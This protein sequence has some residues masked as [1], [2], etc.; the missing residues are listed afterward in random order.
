M[1]SHKPVLLEQVLQVLK[2]EPEQNFVDATLGGGGYTKAILQALKSQGKV[3][4]LDLDLDAITNAQTQ[5][6]EFS[7]QLLVDHRNFRD[8]DKSIKKYDFQSIDGIVA[9]IGLSSYQLDNSGRGIS[10]ESHDRLDMRFDQ[11]SSQPD[12]SFL[13]NNWT[14][15]ELTQIFNKFGEE[16]FSRLIAKGILAF[17]SE[18]KLETADQL[19]QIIQQSLPKPVKHQWQS[20]ARRIFQALR[21]EVNHELENLEVFLPKALNLLKPGGILAVVT[22][23]SLEDRIVK[24]FFKANSL[25]CVCPPEFPICKCG[26]TPTVKILTTKPVVATEHELLENPRARSA[27]MR[28]IQKLK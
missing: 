13:L 22:F 21:I 25:S 17:R 6:A 8:L 26:Q 15:Q 20:S 1:Y 9:D 14:E 4:A 10:F 27:K 2:P 18:Q 28:A 3:L 16:K 7:S 12:A 24:H 5:L 11:S 19:S 23:H